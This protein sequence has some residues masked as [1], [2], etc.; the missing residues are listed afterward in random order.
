M[1][2]VDMREWLPADHLVWFVLETVEALDTSALER[3]RRRGGAGTAGYDRQMLFGLL[4]YA[5]G[6]CPTCTATISW[7]LVTATCAL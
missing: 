4:V 6:D 2:P 5:S 1:L 3:T 7:S